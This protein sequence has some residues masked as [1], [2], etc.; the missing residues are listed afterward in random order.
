MSRQ[1]TFSDLYGLYMKSIE[2]L[3]LDDT[4]RVDLHCHDH[5]SNVTEELWGRLLRL[6]ET[7]LPSEDLVAEL[8][9][10]GSDVITITNHNNARSCWNLMDRGVD[11]LPGCEF[12]C[13]LPD[14]DV[15]IHVL[16]YGFTPDQEQKLH[17]LRRDLYRFAQYANEHQ[18][19]LVLAHPT[20]FYNPRKIAPSRIL[21]RFAMVFTRFEVLNGQR[22][23]RHNLLTWRWLR[24]IDETQM[25]HW[26]KETGLDPFD[27]NAEPY[28]KCAIGGSDD[29]MGLFA[30]S[31]GTWCT[32]PD[33]AHRR[34]DT[35][36]SQLALE[37]IREG[38]TSPFG[39][40]DG[41]TKLSAA[42]LSYFCQLATNMKDPGLVRLFMHQGSLKD[43]LTCLAIGNGLMELQRHKTSMRFVKTLQDALHG[44]PPGPVVRWMA[45]TE[46]G[47]VVDRLKRVALSRKESMEAY[48]SELR[49]LIPDLYRL[50]QAIV[51]SKASQ[52]KDTN[53]G[54]GQP[55]E[56]MEMPSH[57]RALFTGEPHIA[58]PDVV[59]L[60][61]SKRLDQSSFPML[62][63]LL[64]ASANCLS[65]HTM[66]KDAD[67]HRK[68]EQTF[69]SPGI[70]P[71]TLWLTSDDDDA[72]HQQLVA[73]S[74]QID[75]GMIAVEERAF[76]Q[77]HFAPI[78]SVTL[79]GYQF[80]VPDLMSIHA[81]LSNGD[82][83]QVVCSGSPLVGLAGLYLRFTFRIAVHCV[84]HDGFQTYSDAAKTQAATDRV[85]RFARAYYRGFDRLLVTS[86]AQHQALSGPSFL[87]H[88]T[89]LA[90]APDWHSME[91][92]QRADAAISWLRRHHRASQLNGAYPFDL[93]EEITSLVNVQE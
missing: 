14:V 29:H 87:L 71:R 27:F 92:S 41:E 9:R 90:C 13:T 10:N 60:N 40:I 18:I 52:N 49:G 11:V 88:P 17:I 37:A 6:P 26:Q 34:Q 65:A 53:Q 32:V 93:W 12:T 2:P 22:G 84:S 8:K 66:S 7:W 77:H 19:P 43:K 67:L 57:L 39:Y 46:Y 50:F 63:S 70:K 21:A 72:F 81:A 4:L 56:K 62:A 36:L 73:K 16:T 30:G 91:A 79:A 3:H 58:S 42:L 23:L 54:S 44:K 74:P 20:Y 47:P 59:P 80:Q 24:S 83:D 78:T 55:F 68:L 48:L 85:R 38:R 28:Y 35:P 25:E 51:V 75:I 33:L 1:R 45:G 69:L 31:C 5:N 76:A 61:L 64:V 82:Y 89:Q 15:K 86:D